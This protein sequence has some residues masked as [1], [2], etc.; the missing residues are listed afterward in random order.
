MP[1][2]HAIC[3]RSPGRRVEA[4]F[5]SSVVGRQ[6]V[7]SGKRDE[8][9]QLL[10]A[11]GVK[12]VDGDACEV[13]GIGFAGVKGFAGGFGGGTLGAWGEEIVKLF[14]REA[15]NETLKLEGALAR[16]R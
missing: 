14:V 6:D 7:E 3:D 1:H 13:H 12:V 4:Y 16:L 15:I 2:G 11:A 8:V 9:R 5:P 10:Q